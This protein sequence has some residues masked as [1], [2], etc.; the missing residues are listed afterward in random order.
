VISNLNVYFPAVK[1]T[2]ICGT[3]HKQ[4]AAV[5]LLFPLDNVDIV[6]SDECTGCPRITWASWWLCWE[7]HEC[8]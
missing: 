5:L 4:A 2:K 1:K 6:T 3:E 8:M 7:N